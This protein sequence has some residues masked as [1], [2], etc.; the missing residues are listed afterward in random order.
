MSKEHARKLFGGI[1]FCGVG[2]A[3]AKIPRYVPGAQGSQCSYRGVSRV[4][5]SQGRL[6]LGSGKCGVREGVRSQVT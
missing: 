5:D 2:R 1:A 6:P 3:S 4:G